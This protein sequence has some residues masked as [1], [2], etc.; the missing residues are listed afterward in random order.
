MLRLALAMG[1]RITE[2]EGWPVNELR[3]W[4][5]FD[6]YLEPYGREWKQAG[7]IAAAAIAPHVGKLRQPRPED[8]MP[9]WQTPQTAEEIAAELSKLR[10]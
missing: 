9:I 1:I 2:V 6:R 8:F 5:A 10:R 3:E 7:V 4:M